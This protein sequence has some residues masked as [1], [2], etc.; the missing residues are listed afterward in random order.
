MSLLELYGLPVLQNRVFDTR[1]DALN[2][3]VGD[4]ILNQN[5]SSGIV[6]NSAFQNELLTYD[7]NYQNE[8][9][10]SKIFQEHFRN[11]FHLIKTY[12]TGKRVIEIG[13]G[14][15]A[16]LDFLR[17]QG[18]DAIGMDPAY[19][20]ESPFIQKCI[21]DPSA[22]MHGDLIILRHV[23]EHIP[24]TMQFL[25]NIMIANDRQ[26]LIYIE[27]PCLDWISSHKTWFDVFYEHVNYFRK[28]DFNRL[29]GSVIASGNVFNGQYL[30]AIAEL[31]TLRSTENLPKADLFSFPA[32]FLDGIGRIAGRAR[33]FDARQRI[34]WGAASKGALFALHLKQKYAMEF[35]FAIDINPAK[36]NK[37]LPGSAL[38]IL[39]YSAAR[40][41][42]KDDAVIFIMNSNYS[43]EIREITA[44]AFTY[45]E[46]DND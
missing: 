5:T 9:S 17:G 14:K 28:S 12:A 6:S 31:S 22:N 21:F 44:G 27:V 34:V 2:C 8:Q 24:E 25:Q 38:E 16:F 42:L 35:D 29:F 18:I 19:E 37:F 43:A 30:Y 3:P 40:E 46:V 11:I 45:I 1:E 20:G 33:S 10:H 26:G 39:G 13:C 7:S 36:Q 15:G 41:R 23:L 4:V 32:D